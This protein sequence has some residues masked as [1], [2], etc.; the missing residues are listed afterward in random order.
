MRV[1][2]VSVTVTSEITVS[3]HLTVIVDIQD[4]IYV[5]TVSKF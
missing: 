5:P 2:A 4:I 1:L 3:Y